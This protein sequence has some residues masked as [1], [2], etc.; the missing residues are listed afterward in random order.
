MGFST[1]EDLWEDHYCDGKTI[2]GRILDVA[3]S[4]R[5]Q[6]TSRVGISGVV[7]LKRQGADAGRCAI[8]K[9]LLRPADALYIYIYIYIYIKESLISLKQYHLFSCT[10]MK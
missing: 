2:S 1:E 7:V 8:A 9:T 10:F 6:E 3:Q 5:M 4:K